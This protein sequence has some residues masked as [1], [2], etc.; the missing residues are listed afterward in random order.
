MI[1]V[2]PDVIPLHSIVEVERNGEVFEAKALDTGGAIQG[3]II[4]ILVTD[5]DTAWALGRQQ[6]GVR[7]L[8][9]GGG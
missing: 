9:W 7:V 4:D 3:R 1:A 2:D 8:R 6:V 5:T